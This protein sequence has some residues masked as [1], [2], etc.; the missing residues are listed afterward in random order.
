MGDGGADDGRFHHGEEADH[1]PGRGR[2]PAV[3][4]ARLRPGAAPVQQ[5]AQALP[6]VSPRRAGRPRGRSPRRPP[7][8]ARPPPRP[9]GART[10]GPT[11]SLRAPLRVPGSRRLNSRAVARQRAEAPA[12]Y[13]S[14]AGRCGA[15]V[16]AAWAP[17]GSSGVSPS[18]RASR[19]AGLRAGETSITRKGGVVTV[20]APVRRPGRAR[21][22]ARH[23]Q[24]VMSTTSRLARGVQRVSGRSGGGAA[25]RSP[26][27]W[28]GW[29]EAGGNPARSRH[30]VP[31][32]RGKSDPPPV[33]RGTTIG[34]RV[35]A[36]AVMAQSVAPPTRAYPRSPLSA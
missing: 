1:A 5:P 3:A 10:S 4:R 20:S 28:T 26:R 15:A 9:S 16:R 33:V 22:G 2:G 31:A 6:A 23:P 29:T 32:R 11:P 24:L 14:A 21:G 25:V 19:R 12:A 34:T 17:D 35:P 7:P 36:G 8:P 13:R 18:K 30:C 27:S